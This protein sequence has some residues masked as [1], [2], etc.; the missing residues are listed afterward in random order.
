[1]LKGMGRLAVW[2]VY[3]GRRSRRDAGAEG[4]V[5]RTLFCM[6]REPS[7]CAAPASAAEKRRSEAVFDGFL[8]VG[9]R[10]APRRKTCGRAGEPAFQPKR[11]GRAFQHLRK[12]AG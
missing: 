4:S 5:P 1:M 11:A 10:R 2:G 6:E 12:T 9:L 7:V 3:A 8:P